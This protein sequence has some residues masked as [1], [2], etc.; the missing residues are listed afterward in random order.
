MTKTNRSIE[1]GLTVL[2]AVHV[3]GASSLASLA[4]QTGLS[5]PTL[6][7]ICAT[8]ESRRWLIRRSNDGRYRLGS[9]FPQPG[10]LPDAVDRLVAA[11]KTA[12]VHLS[13]TTGLG[14]DL[15]AGIGRGRTEIVDTTRV[16]RKHGVY[17]DAVGFRPS[18]VLSALGAAYLSALSEAARAEAVQ[19]MVRRSAREDIAALPQLADRLRTVAA[20]GYAARAAGHWGRAVD[21]G[22]LPSAIAVPIL[23]DGVPVGAVNLVWNAGDRP[24]EAVAR[25]HLARLQDAAKAIGAAYATLDPAASPGPVRPRS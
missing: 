14:V 20:L 13:E 7:R 6:L 4:R 15:A 17:P 19:D 12:I 10:G 5:K 18:P 22:E 9:G 21:Y 2:E 11:G 24:V 25:D 1:R 3:S 8:L 16:F 23:A